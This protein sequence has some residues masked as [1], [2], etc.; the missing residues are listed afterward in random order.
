[1]RWASTPAAAC[2]TSCGKLPEVAATARLANSGAR[3]ACW[4]AAVSAATDTASACGPVSW[5]CGA[6]ALAGAI[7]PVA[8]AARASEVLFT[9]AGLAAL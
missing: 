9:V 5:L 8:A 7:V 3:L 6:V 1:M 2:C 4:T